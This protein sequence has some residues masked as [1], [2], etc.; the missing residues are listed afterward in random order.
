MSPS[1]LDCTSGGRG[2]IYVTTEKG[3]EILRKREAPVRGLGVKI[4][5]FKCTHTLSD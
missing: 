2:M 5:L 1:L 4:Q 3:K